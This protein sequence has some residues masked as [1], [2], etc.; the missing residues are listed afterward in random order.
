MDTL[1]NVSGQSF[2]LMKHGGGSV[3]LLPGR[4]VILSAEEMKS[5]Q[6]RQLLDGGFARVEQPGKPEKATQQP[7]KEEK[8]GEKKKGEN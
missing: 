4:A 3:H 1:R 6:V 8:R 2:L 5:P 7:V